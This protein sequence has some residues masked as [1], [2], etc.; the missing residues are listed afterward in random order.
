MFIKKLSGVTAFCIFL[1]Y[2]LSTSAFCAENKWLHKE[3]LK[4]VVTKNTAPWAYAEDGQVKGIDY[5]ALQEI[6]RRMGFTFQLE[7]FPF[8]RSF[9]YIKKG[10]RDGILLLYHTRQR[11][12]VVLYSK[13]PMHDST[14]YV[15]VKKG[16]EFAFDSIQ[17]LYGKLIGKNRGFAISDEF[18]KAVLDKKI[19]IQEVDFRERL[20]KMIATDRIDAFVSNYASTKLE[21]KRLGLVNQVVHL[22]R[23][24]TKKG[25]FF[26]LSKKASNVK[27]KTEFLN[28]LSKTLRDIKKE[29]LYDKIVD[30]Y[31][32]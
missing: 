16:N 4:L 6:A 32:D 3:P 25:V 22:P 2:F 19:R 12:S 30:K 29:G 28:T 26:A 9:S 18:D 27:N 24:L 1:A 17:N 23:P 31:L 10:Q 14:H 20:I 15:F 5:E 13:D 11:E 8:K 7:P 21:L